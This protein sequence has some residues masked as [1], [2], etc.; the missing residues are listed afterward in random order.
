[1]PERR[2][3]RG[4]KAE[5]R[6][7]RSEAWAA[8]LLVLKGY[9]ILGW[10]VRTHMGEIDLVARAPGGAVCF[11]EVK[12]RPGSLTAAE[13]VGRRQKARIARAAALYLAARPGLAKKGV[14]F[15][16]VTVVPRRLPRHLRDAWR[17]DEMI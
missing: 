2:T 16:V 8:V 13:A 11:V 10:R 15:D 14:R 5:Q 7:R 3:D 1:M 12:A 17:P 4:R 6:G 9:R